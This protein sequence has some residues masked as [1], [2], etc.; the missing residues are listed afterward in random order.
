MIILKVSRRLPEIAIVNKL[1]NGTDMESGSIHHLFRPKLILLDVY[2][3]LLDMSEVEKKVNTLLESKRGFI[4]WFEMLLQ[5]SFADNCT[6]QFHSFNDISRATM[7][8]VAKILGVKIKDQHL[9]IVVDMM[10]QL[11][12]NEGVQQ[13]LSSMYDQGYRLA[14]LTN[15]PKEIVSERMEMSGL[16]SYFETVLS[17]EEIRKYKPAKEVY[18]WAARTANVDVS[19]VLMV[20]AHS[21]DIAGAAHAGMQT[22]Y[23]KTEND[24]LYPLAPA[25]MFVAKDLTDLAGQ[26]N[27]LFERQPEHVKPEAKQ[28]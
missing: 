11:P 20:S 12:I 3:T 22:A 9:D 1:Q 4:I 27:Q 2:E 14:A 28:V 21:W 23:V 7:S 16:V 24:I 15:S 6:G 13:G 26:L 5:Y 10:K 25:P 17:A 19:E 18:L 8:M